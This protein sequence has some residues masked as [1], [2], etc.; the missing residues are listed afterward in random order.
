[1]EQSAGSVVKG[2]W[3][4]SVIML[5]VLSSH[6]LM[7]KP[8]HVI[9]SSFR[10]TCIPWNSIWQTAFH[11][12]DILNLCTVRPGDNEF[13]SFNK[14]V[15][16]PHLLTLQELPI[17]IKFCF[18]GMEESGSEGLDELVFARKDTF[19]KDV[20]YVCISDNYWLGKT[21]PCITY[22]LRGICYFFMEVRTGWSAVLY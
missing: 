16:F 14:V 13:G 22:G 6:H 8:S 12:T 20:D 7:I 9:C 2:L 3:M 18:E 11:L 21:K 10:I 4:K 5:H 17:N 1:M 15:F 19:L